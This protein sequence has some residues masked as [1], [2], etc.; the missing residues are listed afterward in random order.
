MSDKMPQFQQIV[1]AGEHGYDTNITGFGPDIVF[2]ELANVIAAQNSQN[3]GVKFDNHTPVEITASEEEIIKLLTGDGVYNYR[4][5]QKEAM[6]MK[7]YG[8]I[9]FG[10]EVF[11]GKRYYDVDVEGHWIPLPEEFLEAHRDSCIKIPMRE[12]ARSLNLSN[13][14]AITV[15]EALRQLNFPGL[16]DYGKM[17]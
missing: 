14:V 5:A 12:E 13:A 17:K 11:E 7:R 9:I 6:Y 3:C 4:E 8:G 16:K 15:F 2:S 1:S 10:T